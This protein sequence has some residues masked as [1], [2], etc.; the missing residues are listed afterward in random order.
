M[1]IAAAVSYQVMSQPLDTAETGKVFDFQLGYIHVAR[2]VNS[3]GSLNVG[4]LVEC[5]LSR[6][7]DDWIPLG[8][9]AEIALTTPRDTVRLRWAAQA[10]V[11]AILVIAKDPQQ[12]RVDNPPVA[13]L[14]TSALGATLNNAAVTVT[15]SATLIRAA[16]GGRQSLA[17]QNRG[18]TSIFLGNSGVTVANGFELMPNAIIDVTGISAAIYGIALSGACDVRLLEGST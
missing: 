15:T 18:T 2:F 5:S 7:D 16:N 3:D 9:N 1:S 13:Q 4:A 14:A 11:R 6:A 10:G 17:L 8:F 12:F